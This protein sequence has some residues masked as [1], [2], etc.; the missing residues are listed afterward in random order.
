MK[1]SLSKTKLFALISSMV[2]V[3][4]ISGAYQYFIE[5]L[6]HHNNENKI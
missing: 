3:N 4:D 2:L 6:I 1:S 5:A